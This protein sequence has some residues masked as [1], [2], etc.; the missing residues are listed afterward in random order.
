ML[1]LKVLWDMYLA[2]DANFQEESKACLSNSQSILDD[3]T[4]IFTTSPTKSNPSTDLV[5][6]TIGS[7]DYVP[8]IRGC[9]KIFVCDGYRLRE[10]CSKSTWRGSKSY[11]AGATN[12]QGCDYQWR[13]RLHEDVLLNT[14]CRCAHTSVLVKCLIREKCCP[15][16][17]FHMGGWC[18][19][20]PV[21]G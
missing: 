7:F 4:I 21:Y 10:S 15:T 11:R 9:K 13:I 18:A 8:E 1:G 20:T 17:L 12:N 2:H 19:G 6:A 5:Q 3:L 14:D 16:A